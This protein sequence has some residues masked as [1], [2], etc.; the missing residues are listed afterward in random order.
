M[1]EGGVLAISMFTNAGEES[2]L[3]LEDDQKKRFDDAQSNFTKVYYFSCN[4][5]ANVHLTN[6]RTK[7]T[8]QRLLLLFTIRKI[9]YFTYCKT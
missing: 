6:Y 2:P 1:K 5:M 4:L 3:D 8:F 9:A 7:T